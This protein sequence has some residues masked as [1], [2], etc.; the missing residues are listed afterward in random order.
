MSGDQGL[1][2]LLSCVLVHCLFVLCSWPGVKY[3]VISPAVGPTTNADH[4]HFLLRRITRGNRRRNQDNTGAQS[5]NPILT[6]CVSLPVLPPYRSTLPRTITDQALHFNPPSLTETPL[7]GN[8]S[9]D[10]IGAVN[11]LQMTLSAVGQHPISIFVSFSPFLSFGNSS[12]CFSSFS[13]VFL[14]L[15]PSP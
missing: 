9:Q 10:L 8:P 1:C 11:R 14:D 5:L 7:Q 2:C 13:F 15:S 3:L 4:T 12:P 6:S